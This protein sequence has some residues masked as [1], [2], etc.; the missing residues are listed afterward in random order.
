MAEYDEL[1]LY[2]LKF[3][4]MYIEFY[5][6]VSI[7]GFLFFSLCNAVSRRLKASDFDSN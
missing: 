7:T 4:Q 1:F 5:I 2:F 6:V 3:K